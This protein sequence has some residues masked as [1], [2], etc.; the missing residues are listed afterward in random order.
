MLS[1]IDYEYLTWQFKLK[2]RDDEKAIKELE[3]QINGI[4]VEYLGWQFE[5]VQLQ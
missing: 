2:T 3:E 4:N 5:E 1:N